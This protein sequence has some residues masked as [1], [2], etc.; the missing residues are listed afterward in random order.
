MINTMNFKVSAY[1][2]QRWDMDIFTDKKKWRKC[3]YEYAPKHDKKEI[4]GQ[5]TLGSTVLQILKFS[6]KIRWENDES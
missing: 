6:A 2:N 1:N 4:F 5:N 3:H